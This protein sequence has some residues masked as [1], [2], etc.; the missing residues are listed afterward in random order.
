MTD[1]IL[2]GMDRLEITLLTMIDLSRCFDVVGH[3]T[4][5]NKLQSLQIST[6]WFKRYVSGHVQQ[7]KIGEKLS[8]PLPIN[9]GTFQGTCLG[10]LLF[11]VASNDLPC[12][13][14]DKVNGF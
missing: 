7:V 14:P 5:L 1:E 13:I 6:E 9:I 8:T 10:P 3:E 12:H 2:K 11:K 4:L